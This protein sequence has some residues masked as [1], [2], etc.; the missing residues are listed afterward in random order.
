LFMP[1]IPFMPPLGPPKPNI[2]IG[3]MPI[4]I[5]LTH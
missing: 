4:G 3:F 1:F 2:A 5:P